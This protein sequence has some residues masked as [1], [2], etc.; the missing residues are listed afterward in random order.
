MRFTGTA[1]DS[2]PGLCKFARESR[3]LEEIS[4]EFGSPDKW[5]W[6]VIKK[7]AGKLLRLLRK[8]GKETEQSRAANLASLGG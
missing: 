4:P 8:Q 6:S 3:C 5:D 1:N 2:M 7:K